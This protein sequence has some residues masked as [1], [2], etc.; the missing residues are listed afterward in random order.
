MSGIE[1]TEPD[2]DGIVLHKSGSRVLVW[3]AC[4][5]DCPQGKI[6]AQTRCRIWIERKHLSHACVEHQKL[7][8]R[9]DR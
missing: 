2:G 4:E 8:N 3:C 5:G 9:F 1:I 6:G 7:M